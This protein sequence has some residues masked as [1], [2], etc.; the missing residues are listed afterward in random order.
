[1]TR[2]EREKRTVGAMIALHCRANHATG[3]N[4]C[5]DCRQL[6][7]YAFARLE[8]CPFGAGK[9]TCAKCPVHCYKPD[10]REQIRKVMRYSGPRMLYRHPVLALMHQIDSLRRSSSSKVG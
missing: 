4:L 8:R 1:M 9:T 5:E 10:M 7:D 2:I 6:C 3:S